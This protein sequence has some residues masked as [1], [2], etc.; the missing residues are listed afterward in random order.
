MNSK[1]YITGATGK[2]GRVVLEKTKAIPLVRRASGLENEIVTDF[3][4]EQLKKI[5]KDADAVL[6]IAGSVDTLNEKKMREANVELTRRIVAALPEKCRIVFAGSISV[7]GKRLAEIPAD[8]ETATKPDSFYARSKYQ[9]EKIVAGH[10]NHV[11]LRIGAVYGTQF[12]DYFKVL[13]I[14]DKGK[15]KIIGDGSNHIPFVNVG[16][17]ADV[18]ANAINK[19]SGIYVITGDSITQKEV[20]D[21]AANGLRRKPLSGHVSM[22]TVQLLTSAKE[23]LYKLGGKKPIITNEHIGVLAYDRVFDCSKAK[24]ELGFSPRSMINGL[25][26]VVQ[27]YRKRNK[28]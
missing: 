15:M 18:F 9:A 11:I 26:E 24:K 6:H 19:G 16:D 20:L 17:V 14:I 28:S 7:Y 23:I 21:L 13:S 1:I 8:E 5:L 10:P 3:S 12:E 25:N 2:L 27:E 22:A 4:E